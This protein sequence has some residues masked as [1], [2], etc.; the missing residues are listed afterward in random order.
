MTEDDAATLLGVVRRTRSQ[1]RSRLAEPSWL[2]W[3]LYGVLS[4]IAVPMTWWF[5]TPIHGVYWA[6]AVPVGVAITSWYYRR[7]EVRIG[8]ENR[9]TPI[10][11][12]MGVIVVGAFGTGAL[13][14]ALGWPMLAATGPAF[15][16]AAGLSIFAMVQRNA[17]LA[18]AAAAVTM[19]A[20]A[21]LVTGTG[22]HSTSM[23][24]LTAC[25][26]VGIAVGVGSRHSSRRTQ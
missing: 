9:I 11:V 2:P 23:I 8:A 5:G 20:G 15:A 14:G 6:L 16:V 26:L 10:L 21:L 7:L 24:M 19:L 3:V 25:G 12:G 4:L 17:G 13:G 1:T 18:L 22:A